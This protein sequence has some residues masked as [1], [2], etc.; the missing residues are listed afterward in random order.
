[1]NRISRRHVL[2]ATAATTAIAAGTTGLAA[3]SQ[4]RLIVISDV[5]IGDNSPTV[6][7]QRKYH[8]PYLKAVFDYVIANADSVSELL[9]LGDFVDFWT[10]PPDRRPPAFADIAAANPNVFGPQGMLNAALLAL[11]GRITYVPGNHDMA[12]AQSDLD[13]V[14]VPPYRINL[15]RTDAYF[16]SGSGGRILCAHGNAWTMFNAPDPTTRLAPLPIGHF[17]TRSFCYQLSHLL[18]PGQTVADLADQGIPNGIDFGSLIQSIDSS[19]IETVVDYASAETGLPLAAPIVLA[20]GSTTSLGEVKTLY[21]S[22]WSNWVSQCAHHEE[23]GL[24]AFKA[25]MADIGNGTYLPWF[26]QRQALPA[27]AKLVIYGHTHVPVRGLKD[28]FID[29]VNTGFD[30]ASMPDMSTRHFT[31]VEVD[32]ATLHAQIMEVVPDSTGRFLVRAYSGAEL[33]EAVPGP[34]LDYSSYVTIDNRLGQADLVLASA[35]AREGYFV[36]PPPA[37][38]PRGQ[39]ARYWVQD[40]PGGSGS[41]AVAN[42]QGANGPLTLRVRCPTGLGANLASGADFRS[43]TGSDDYGALD[44]A[45]H[46]GHPFFVQFIV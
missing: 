7:Y 41:E 42:Y 26:A 12:I 18:K 21:R 8:E 28:G 10:Y 34:A 35:D 23:G 13:R 32:L 29:Y 31:F 36:V 37:Q 3:P 44:Q 39:I 15:Q 19:L 20:D 22:L 17:A 5:H 40:K 24:L 25:A 6:W 2:A 11:K 4:N 9:I 43:K 30:C 27:G 14:S 1:M 38:V 45:P 16:P 46:F 33:D